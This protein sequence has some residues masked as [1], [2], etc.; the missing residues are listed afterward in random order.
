M[1]EFAGQR[2][3]CWK[4]PEPPN[5]IPAAFGYDV[6]VSNWDSGFAQS[7]LG[8]EAQVSHDASLQVLNINYPSEQLFPLPSQ[9]VADTVN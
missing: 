1:S 5:Q 9:R 4:S 7:G 6:M 8:W 3:K 2:M